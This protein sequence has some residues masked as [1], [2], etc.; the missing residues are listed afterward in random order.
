MNKGQL[1][2]IIAKESL[3]IAVFILVGI[4][5][6]LLFPHLYGYYM[7]HFATRSAE[8]YPGALRGWWFLIVIGYFLC[9]FIRY[10]QDQQ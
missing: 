5:G 6:H 1:R 7:H 2:K 8:S 10:N 3:I 9:L 4:L